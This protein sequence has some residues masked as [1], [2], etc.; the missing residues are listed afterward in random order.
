[1][2]N[3]IPKSTQKGVSVECMECLNKDAKKR[4][5]GQMINSLRMPKWYYAIVLWI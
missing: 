2:V 5:K 1:M 4:K 3:F